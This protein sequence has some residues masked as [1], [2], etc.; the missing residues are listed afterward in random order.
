MEK[1]KMRK[2]EI[3]KDRNGKNGQKGEEKGET[4]EKVRQKN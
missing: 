4:N 1:K 3:Q 2:H